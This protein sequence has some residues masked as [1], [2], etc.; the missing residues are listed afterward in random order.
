MAARWEEKQTTQEKQMTQ[1]KDMT[2]DVKKE[3]P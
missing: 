3:N 1:E 2:Q